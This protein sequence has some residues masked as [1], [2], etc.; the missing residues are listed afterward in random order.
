MLRIL[1]NSLNL[2][3]LHYKSHHFCYNFKC[4]I[5][6]SPGTELV[7]FKILITSRKEDA[8]HLYYLIGSNAG[9]KNK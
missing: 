6:S 8:Q 3:N 4:A 1:S 9:S 7:D 5:H 2:N